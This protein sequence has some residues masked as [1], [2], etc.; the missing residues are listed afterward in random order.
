MKGYEKVNVVRKNRV[1]G[2]NP[3][4]YKRQ[5]FR[6]EDDYINALVE[7][8][9]DEDPR[10][11][12]FRKH[13]KMIINELRQLVVHDPVMTKF[14][15]TGNASDLKR[16]LEETKADQKKWSIFLRYANVWDD[17]LVNL[18]YLELQKIYAVVKLQ[19]KT[20]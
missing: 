1:D 8:S 4:Q 6:N 14:M 5:V 11:R 19:K 12:E 7:S 17:D 9:L 16:N 18:G 20:A 13:K 15:L 3:N 10:E 2:V